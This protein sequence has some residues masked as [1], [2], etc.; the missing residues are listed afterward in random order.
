VVFFIV[1][2]NAGTPNAVPKIGKQFNNPTG[3]SI[4]L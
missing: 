4:N 3:F 2:T 1:G